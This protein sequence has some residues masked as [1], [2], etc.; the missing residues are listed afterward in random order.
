MFDV[1]HFPRW[2]ACRVFAL[3]AALA[4]CSPSAETPSSPDLPG[5]RIVNDHAV[6]AGCDGELE[7]NAEGACPWIL[8]EAA[9]I[10]SGSVHPYS[11]INLKGGPVSEDGTRS[12]VV[13]TATLLRENSPSPPPQ[14][15]QCHM[16]RGKVREAGVIS[17]RDFNDILH[18]HKGHEYVGYP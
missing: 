7:R 11:E 18:G 10:N 14:F 1:A 13:G 3:S 5:V 15:V 9:V 16:E 12:I 4:A 17:E 2:H 6:V 8:C